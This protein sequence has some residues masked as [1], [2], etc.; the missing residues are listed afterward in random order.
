MSLS[1]QA[2][3]SHWSIRYTANG[4]VGSLSSSFGCKLGTEAEAFERSTGERRRA[5]SLW[6]PYCST[7]QMSSLS[8]LR[9]FALEIITPK[10]QHNSH[11]SAA[12]AFASSCCSWP[13]CGSFNRNARQV[14]V[15]E[16]ASIGMAML[17]GPPEVEAAQ[18]SR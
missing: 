9:L 14:H 11:V 17:H 8:S 6:A 10:E 15:E 16:C 13:C 1:F 18:A 3:P 2:N 12:T 7:Q 4:A 5:L